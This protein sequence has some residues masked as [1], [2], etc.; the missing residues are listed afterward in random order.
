MAAISG[1]FMRVALRRGVLLVSSLTGAAASAQLTPPPS[2]NR[3]WQ[4]DPRPQYWVPDPVPPV[5]EKHETTDLAVEDPSTK[6]VYAMLKV[7]Y[8]TTLNVSAIGWADG[9]DPHGTV[10]VE[11]LKDNMVVARSEPQSGLNVVHAGTYASVQLDPGRQNKI[12]A[13]LYGHDKSYRFVQ[14]RTSDLTQCP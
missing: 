13:R 8:P 11:I 14:L 12:S 2:A 9:G 1:V 4:V 10:G 3:F 6:V 5:C 7:Q